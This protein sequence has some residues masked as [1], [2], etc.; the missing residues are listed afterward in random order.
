M[1][2]LLLALCLTLLASPACAQ[3]TLTQRWAMQEAT[4]GTE[5]AN[6][7]TSNKG[8]YSSGTYTARG[9]PGGTYLSSIDFPG[10]RRFTLDNQFSA[11]KDA[12]WSISAWVLCDTA[13][14]GVIVGR[15]AASGWIGMT[16]TTTVF[17]RGFGISGT[18][19]TVTA[20]TGTW[21]HYVVTHLAS[22]DAVNVYRDTT[23]SSSNPTTYDGTQDADWVGA[24]AFG[25]TFHNGGICDLRIYSGVLSTEE[26]QA[27]FDQGKPQN[28]VTPVVTGTP[29]VGE[30]LSVADGTWS[31][32]STT[33]R[34]WKHDGT[35]I[36]GATGT[37][38]VV[39]SAYIGEDITCQITRTNSIGSLPATSNAVGPVEAA[40]GPPVSVTVATQFGRR[41]R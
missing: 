13:G 24:T 15:N 40:E 7:V 26:R 16:A 11:G 30:T 21:H 37:T 9:G 12:N 25:S 38:Y 23:G 2:R 31:D 39:Q 28:S 5:I 41:R 19:F 33:A 4:G 22:S 14:S 35:N 3:A 36:S 10:D 8:T 34:Q 32:G 29:T 18:N 17:V 1:K 6:S 27:L 20:D